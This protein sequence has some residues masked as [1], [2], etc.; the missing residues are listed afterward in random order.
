MVFL[1]W[2]VLAATEDCQL[3]SSRD[4]DLREDLQDFPLLV[5]SRVLLLT[6]RHLTNNPRKPS[7]LSSCSEVK[8]GY[9]MASCLPNLTNL[10]R[11]STNKTH[12]R[13]S[14]LINS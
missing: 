11:D 3:T 4:S 7:C 14:Y 9:Q 2:E 8:V 6:P 10:L 5:N 1:L 13:I 12:N